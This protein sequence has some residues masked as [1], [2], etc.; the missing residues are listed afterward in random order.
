VKVGIL[1]PLPQE[2]K[3]LTGEK[4]QPAHCKKITAD[5][6]VCQSGV[7]RENTQRAA[8]LLISK[9]VEV[10]ISWGSAA[11]LSPEVAGGDLLIP[12]SVKVHDKTYHTHG[13]FNNELLNQISPG[14]PVHQGSICESA[15]LLTSVENKKQ[16]FES[17][18]CLAADMESGALAELAAEKNIPFSV[19]RAVS[20]PVNMKLSKAVLAGIGQDGKFKLASFVKTALISPWEWVSIIKLAWNFKKAQKT[21]N[22]VA[23]ILK[24]E[25]LAYGC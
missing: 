19:I 13:S 10:L 6:T 20:D 22:I 3:M 11:G 23:K 7:G 5:I 12:R 9:D 17:S 4:I 25:N 2:M 8:Q 16:L 15:R 24:A 14:I 18:Q 1:V 21:L